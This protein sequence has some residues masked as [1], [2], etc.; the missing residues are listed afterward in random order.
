MPRYLS[1]LQSLLDILQIP[2]LT[3]ELNENVDVFIVCICIRVIILSG[4][5]KI[6]LT[7]SLAVQTEQEVSRN[8][9][10]RTSVLEAG[11]ACSKKQITYVRFIRDYAQFYCMLYTIQIDTS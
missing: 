10:P 1:I 11:L 5:K 6:F 9:C 3:E 2:S 7:F 8:F 4:R